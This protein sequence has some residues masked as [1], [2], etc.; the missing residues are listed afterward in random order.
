M[1]SEGSG[2]SILRSCDTFHS[3]TTRDPPSQ[4]IVILVP[5]HWHS[6][7]RPFPLTPRPCPG[8]HLPSSRAFQPYLLFSSIS[9]DDILIPRSA[10]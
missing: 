9:Q 8:S 5:S 1:P 10:Y 4:I 3:F 7:V 2:Y 6:R